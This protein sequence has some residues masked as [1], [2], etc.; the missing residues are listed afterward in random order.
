MTVIQEHASV[1]IILQMRIFMCLLFILHSNALEWEELKEQHLT[2]LFTS[3]LPPLL[4]VVS[5]VSNILFMNNLGIGLG[6]L[7]CAG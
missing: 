3:T 6:K 1:K 2:I 5:L 7:C 4:Y